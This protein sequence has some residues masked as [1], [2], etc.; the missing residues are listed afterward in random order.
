MAIKTTPI[1]LECYNEANARPN[2]HKLPFAASNIH[3]YYSWPLA[4]RRA[5]EWMRALCIRRKCLNMSAKLRRPIEPWTTKQILI[6]L[7]ASGHSPLEYHQINRLNEN[8]SNR[9]DEIEYVD[10]QSS[11]TRLA[12]GL[13]FARSLLAG[14]GDLKLSDSNDKEDQTVDIESDLVVKNRKSNRKA[15]SNVDLIDYDE[16]CRASGD[17]SFVQMSDGGVYARK[18]LEMVRVY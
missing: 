14:V 8:Y 11:V 6:W 16:L 17:L 3:E 10:S 15:S 4:K 12:E 18:Q 5:S 7:R 13:S 2:K 1:V 9:T